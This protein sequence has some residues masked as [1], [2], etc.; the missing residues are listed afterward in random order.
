MKLTLQNQHIKFCFIL[1]ILL[2]SSCKRS[3]AKGFGADDWL[4]KIYV[5]FAVIGLVIITTAIL[6]FFLI[7]EKIG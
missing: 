3:L 6:V 1:F 4:D 5:V 7:L 2:S